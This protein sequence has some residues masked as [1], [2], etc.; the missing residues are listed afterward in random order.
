MGRGEGRDASSPETGITLVWNQ[1]PLFRLAARA[2]EPF[3]IVSARA[4]SSSKRLAL[5]LVPVSLALAAC[6]TGD[7]QAQLAAVAAAREAAGLRP[8]V[9][10][11]SRA[12]ASSFFAGKT[13]VS[14]AFDRGSQVSYM[15]PDGTIY[16]WF[17]GNPVVLRGQWT[18]EESGG[19]R[20][21]AGRPV[22]ETNVCF[23]Y[24][25]NSPNAWTGQRGKPECLPAETLARWSQDRADGDVFGLS[26]KRE[27]PF[28]LP[29]ERTTIVELRKRMGAR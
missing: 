8:E 29:P 14:S 6:S 21:Y 13:R 27:V 20:P 9:V 15:A 4:T 26:E 24:G 25:P 12:E 5:A 2:H 3:P 17:P 7:S 18:L 16:L 28:V 11:M 1:A 23:F 19:Y 10:R 22:S